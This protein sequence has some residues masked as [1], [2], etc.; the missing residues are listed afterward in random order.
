[1][2]FGG[3]ILIDVAMEVVLRYF[4]KLSSCPCQWGFVEKVGLVIIFSPIPCRQKRLFHRMQIVGYV[5]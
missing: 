2:D 5:R 4:L 3:L 1:M